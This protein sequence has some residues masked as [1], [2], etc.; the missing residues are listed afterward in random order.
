[1]IADQ[2][3][4]LH[5]QA[6]IPASEV[7][8]G[9]GR[10]GIWGAA[11]LPVLV[12]S[13][14]RV[15]AQI[16]AEAQLQAARGDP[17]APDGLRRAGLG[18]QHGLAPRPAVRRRPD[19]PQPGPTRRAAV[20]GPRGRPAARRAPGARGRAAAPR[21]APRASRTPACPAPGRPGGPGRRRGRGS[22]RRRRTAR[23]PVPTPGWR[24]PRPAP[25][26]PRGGRGAT[27]A[28]PPE[29]PPEPRAARGGNGTAGI[30]AHGTGVRNAVLAST[31]ASSAC[32]PASAAGPGAPPH[33]PQVPVP[34]TAPRRRARIPAS[35]WSRVRPRRRNRANGSA[36][37]ASAMR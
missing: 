36:S 5:S 9:Q 8:H 32:W 14:V 31:P 18:A 7:R 20:R 19:L 37:S 17:V 33:P 35:T 29:A 13:R 25:P 6:L 3:R 15:P 34:G 2:P 22:A 12:R 4:L 23:S 10:I 24:H 27:A 21:T 26:G 16:P 30:G 28:D 1:M 11:G